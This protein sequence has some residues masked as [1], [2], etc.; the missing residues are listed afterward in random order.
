MSEYPSQVELNPYVAPESYGRQTQASATQPASTHLSPLSAGLVA[1]ASTGIAGGVFGFGIFGFFGAAFGLFIAGA[2]AAPVAAVIFVVLR[3]VGPAGVSR[4][5]AVIASA[6]CGL[7]TGFGSTVSL[8]GNDSM[9]YAA[10]AGIVGG[11][12]SGIG[13]GL[14]SFSRYSYYELDVPPAVWADLEAQLD[15][16]AEENE[17]RNG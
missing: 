15:D 3:I 4:K 13:V 10:I 14:M 2:A 6:L 9:P 8:F 16:V 7:T 1:W 12:V 5:T 11:I 17:R